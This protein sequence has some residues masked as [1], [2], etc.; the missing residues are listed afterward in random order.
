MTRFLVWL[1]L[2]FMVLVTRSAAFPSRSALSSG[3]RL[4]ADVPDFSQQASKGG[5]QE[6]DVYVSDP[7]G[8]VCNA[9]VV[10]FAYFCLTFPF[11][12][13]SFEPQFLSETV[14][15]PCLEAAKTQYSATYS[16]HKMILRELTSPSGASALA[17][18]HSP[19]SLSPELQSF[20]LA[21]HELSLPFNIG[22]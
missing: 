16:D 9:P 7:V 12:H 19:F 3:K 8:K 1:V 4:E 2:V 15:S 13:L 11:C 5:V 21:V 18:L 20:P 17:L 22:K 14:L 6:T 10:F